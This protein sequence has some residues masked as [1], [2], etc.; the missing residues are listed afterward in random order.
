MLHDVN[1]RAV[2]TVPAIASAMRGNVHTTARSDVM[3]GVRANAAMVNE[4][5]VSRDP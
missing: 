4:V 5:K 3:N 1:P 2:L